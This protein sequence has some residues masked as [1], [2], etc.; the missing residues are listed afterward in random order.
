MYQ[1]YLL[2][3][4]VFLFWCMGEGGIPLFFLNQL[5]RNITKGIPP[6]GAEPLGAFMSIINRHFQMF[7]I[8]ANQKQVFKFP[9]I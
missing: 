9:L 4:F 6:E 8:L 7:Y 3:S 1:L 5:I 2:A